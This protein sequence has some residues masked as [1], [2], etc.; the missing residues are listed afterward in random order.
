M[1]LNDWRR[2]LC[3]ELVL[4][5]ACVTGCV[6]EDLTSRTLTAAKQDSARE[7][8][9]E[10]AD[11]KEDV[12]EPVAPRLSDSDL[13]D[14]AESGDVESVEMAIKQQVD[15]NSPNDNGSTALMLAAF[16]GHTEIVEK[17]LATQARMN[18][19]DVNN[20]TALMYAASGPYPK[21]VELL[22][23]KGAEVNATD[24]AEHWDALMFAAAEGQTEVVK[25][26]LE[27]GADPT[28]ADIDGETALQFA[29]SK[30]HREV[31]EVLS[32]D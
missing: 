9:V 1:L 10:P 3:F 4:G 23:R 28:H 22:L 24:G 30:G 32:R 15:V 19:R 20:R 29:A 7:D 12:H 14:A 8:K 21:T 11:D 13:R 5:V 2:T 16:N 25:V 31:V 6:Q 26:L 18:H 27:H 17:L